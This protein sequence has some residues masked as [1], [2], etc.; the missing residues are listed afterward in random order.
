MVDKTALLDSLRERV[1][2]DL[3]ALVRRQ[4]DAQ[5]GATH[6][7]S[8]AE[9]AKDTRATEQAYLARGLAERVAD[10][11]RT[12]TALATLELRSFERDGPIAVSALV[13][14]TS[15]GAQH[16]TATR[17]A[18]FVV[19]GAGGL[20][21]DEAGMRIQ[22]VTPVS[23]LGRSLLGLC[24]GDE[25]KVRMPRGERRFEVLEVR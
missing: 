25:G 1:A 21:L 14:V 9:H 11:R 8:R 19:P 23:P 3:E 22:T 18:W 12:A 16:D 10:L 20:E 2:A 6:D 13:F 15:E 7:E 24:R 17:E 4:K 5:A